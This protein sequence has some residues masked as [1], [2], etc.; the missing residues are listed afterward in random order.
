LPDP[1]PQ[2]IGTGGGYHISVAAFRT[3]QRASTVAAAIAAKGFPVAT[4]TNA[5]TGWH[6]IVVGP[7]V[8]AG[9]AQ[10]AQRTL[11]RDGFSETLIAPSPR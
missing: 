7:F 11:A 9:D 10:A 5:Q 1:A 4:R 6:Q 2:T 8:S 3:R